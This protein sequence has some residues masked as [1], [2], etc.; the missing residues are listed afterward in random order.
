MKVSREEKAEH[1]EKIIETAAR[2]FREKGF[3]GIGVADLMKEAGLTHGGFYGH[4]SSKEELVALAAQRAIRE[5]AARWKQVM[6]SAPDRP[7]DALIR[8]YLTAKHEAHPETGCLFAALGSDLA[9]QPA[10]VRA[11]VTEE[12]ETVLDLIANELQGRTKAA[13]RKTAIFVLSQLVG[14]IILART[15]YDPEKSADVLRAS[16][17]LALELSA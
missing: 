16:L 1:R 12:L 9:R 15:M 5:T 7:L 10:S 3:D 4:F 8:Y 2:R 11:V 6:A 17:D 13:R 14:A